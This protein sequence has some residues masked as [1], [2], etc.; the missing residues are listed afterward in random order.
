MALPLNAVHNRGGTLEERGQLLGT[1]ALLSTKFAIRK[2]IY[3]YLLLLRSSV[4]KKLFYK[5]QPPY[6]QELIGRSQAVGKGKMAFSPWQGPRC[7]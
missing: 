2:T 7:Y 1:K 5:P 4:Q 3:G 6:C